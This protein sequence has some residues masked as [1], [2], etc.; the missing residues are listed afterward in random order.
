MTPSNVDPHSNTRIV[1]KNS[2]RLP[3]AKIGG[4]LFFSLLLGQTR[5]S[6]TCSRFF[7][8]GAAIQ[9]LS[10]RV[11]S[12][13]VRELNRNSSIAIRSAEFSEF[14]KISVLVE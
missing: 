5:P 9:S 13:T 14:M 6:S 12:I 1:K 7:L 10:S 4:F 8:I 11:D 3:D 2:P